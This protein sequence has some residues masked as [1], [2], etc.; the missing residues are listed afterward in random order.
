[1]ERFS[2]CAA[3]LSCSQ[4]AQF[5][6]SREAVRGRPWSFYRSLLDELNHVDPV[7][8]YYLELLWYYIFSS[9]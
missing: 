5:A 2:S 6:V 1:M 3:I 7:A 8:S 9:R 4:G